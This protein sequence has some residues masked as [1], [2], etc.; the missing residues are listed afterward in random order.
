ML[1]L[2]NV[3]PS[4][5]PS[6]AFFIATIWVG[7]CSYEDADASSAGSYELACEAALQETLAPSSPYR[8]VDLIRSETSSRNVVVDVLFDANIGYGP[9]LRHEAR[10]RFFALGDGDLTPFA[11]LFLMVSLQV[12][13]ELFVPCR[14]PEFAKDCWRFE[15]AQVA[16]MNRL[17]KL[18]PAASLGF[19]ERRSSSAKHE[20]REASN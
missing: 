8:R 4:R 11:A 19:L 18:S 15:E 7:G 5:W 10:C 2:C 12:D 1:G 9:V 3:Y 17:G 16:A 13:D 20:S 14:E 6:F